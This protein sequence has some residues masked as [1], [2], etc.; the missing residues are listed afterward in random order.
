MPRNVGD[1]RGE[2]ENKDSSHPPASRLSQWRLRSSPLRAAATATPSDAT[3]A[4]AGDRRHRGRRHR[5][6][7][8]SQPAAGAGIKLA[9]N[10]WTG[11]AVNAN[12]AKVVLESKLGT[13]TELVD[14]RRER[15]VGRPRRRRPRRQPRDLAVGSRRRLQDLHRPRRRASSTSAC[16][17]RGQDRLVRADVRHRP[18]PRAGD[19]GRLQGSRHWPSCSQRPRPATWASS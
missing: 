15:R 8:P 3:T 6:S 2:H 12:V 1:Q 18:A 10:P 17:A 16:S 13:P 11:S 7:R 14:T 9:V 4:A 19:L 5:R